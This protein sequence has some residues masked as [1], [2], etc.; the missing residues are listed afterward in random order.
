MKAVDL[1]AGDRLQ[2]VN[3]EYVTVE[4]VQH[5]ILESPIKVYNF[6]VQDNHTYYVGD[7]DETD[8][9]LVHNACG[10]EIH[11]FLTNKSKKYTKQFMDIVDK[12][13]LDLDDD[14]NKALMKHRGRH[15]N[16]Y[17]DYMLENLKRIDQLSKGNQKKFLKEFKRVKKH[18]MKNP[19]MLYKK[20]WKGR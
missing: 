16:K 11:H 7:G 19:D 3:G 15:A 14:W 6:E 13:G 5:E 9:V 12:Y 4:Q 18:I 17:H 1:R 20:Y 2:L 8:S 10:K